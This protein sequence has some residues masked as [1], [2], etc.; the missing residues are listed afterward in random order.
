[1]AWTVVSIDDIKEVGELV[2]VMLRHPDISVYHAQD[3]PS[4]L[5]LIHEVMPDLVML[6]VMLPGMSG[7]EVHAAIR[8][9][10]KL[11]S[12][13]IIM[14]SVLTAKPEQLLRFE[15]SAIDLYVAKP[16]DARQLR[17]QVCRM[18]GA[19]ILWP[20]TGALPTPPPPPED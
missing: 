4:G 8:A 16:F 3:G 6:D 13:P 1:M 12:L 20:S 10:D 7:W 14:L 2:R 5:A 17:R 11:R 19:D 9:D 15:K 18:L